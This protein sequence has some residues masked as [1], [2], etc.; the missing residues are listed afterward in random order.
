MQIFDGRLQRKIRTDFICLFA[1]FELHVAR[2]FTIFQIVI[3]HFLLFADIIRYTVLDMDKPLFHMGQYNFLLHV[4]FHVI[5]TGILLAG[6]CKYRLR[7]YGNQRVWLRDI[8]A[9]HGDNCIHLFASCGWLSMD[10]TE[11]EANFS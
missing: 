11:I 2:S 6:S 9:D 5:F 1:S 3:P 10:D 4:Q 8:L 7:W